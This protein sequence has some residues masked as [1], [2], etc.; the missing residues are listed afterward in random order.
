MET[1]TTTYKIIVLLLLA[2]SIFATG[3][4]CTGRNNTSAN[5]TFWDISGNDAAWRAVI[6]DFERLNKGMKVN[7]IAKSSATYEEELLDAMASGNGPDIFTIRNDWLPRYGDKISPLQTD[8]NFSVRKLQTDYLP[9][10]L[11][12]F[13]IGDKVYGLAPSVDVLMMYYNR[14][15]L[16]SA[17]IARPP[18][19]WPELVNST[20]RLTRIGFDGRINQS[21]VSLGTANNITNASE[22]LQ[23]L[24][25]QSDVKFYDAS[26]SNSSLSTGNQDENGDTPATRALRFYTQFADPVSR[27]YTWNNRLENDVDA[28]AQE[29]VAII[30]G[31]GDLRKILQAKN[32][33]LDYGIASLP[34]LSATG[35][36]TNYT[37]Y[38]AQTVWS[39]SNQAKATW[40]FIKFANSA[41]QSQKY[42]NTISQVSTHLDA[43]SL[44]QRDSGM[45]VF[46]DN[47]LTAKSVIKPQTARFEKVL[48]E[49]IEDASSVG[50]EPK[51]AVSRA[52]DKIDSLLKQ[53][54][55][56]IHGAQP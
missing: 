34:Q 48:E 40:E 12:D 14:K 37:Q 25:L 5:L 56:N 29:K 38:L 22:I 36:K 54:P 50:L 8:N 26:F 43:I 10:L 33:F 42:S 9:T 39:G 44:Q 4:S 49:M 27:V 18:A 3:L 31:F 51:E 13:L 16:T 28:F 30:F 23:A 7:Y 17:G 24:F 1:K 52:E 35:V 2:I 53:Y 11:N 32:A 47:A 15:L 19:T 6:S 46:A 55:L 21:A 20:S 41:E 45:G